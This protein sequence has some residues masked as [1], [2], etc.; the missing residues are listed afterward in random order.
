[1]NHDFLLIVADSIVLPITFT[2]FVLS[3][4]INFHSCFPENAHLLLFTVADIDFT[5]VVPQTIF[6]TIIKIFNITSFLLIFVIIP[7]CLLVNFVKQKSLESSIPQIHHSHKL[8]RNKVKPASN[9][10]QKSCNIYEEVLKQSIKDRPA[11]HQFQHRVGDFVEGETEVEGSS[12]PSEKDERIKITK[13]PT[14]Y[15]NVREEPHI[16]IQENVPECSSIST[17]DKGILTQDEIHIMIE[18]ENNLS[19]E[20]YIDVRDQINESIDRTSEISQVNYKLDKFQKNTKDSVMSIAH[21]SM[22]AISAFFFLTLYSFC[23]EYKFLILFSLSK[24]M[25]SLPILLLLFN[26]KLRTYAKRRIFVVLYKFFPNLKY[27]SNGSQ[28]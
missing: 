13:P 16:G 27:I 17:N 23:G 9:Q 28:E 24:S 6:H 22:A 20:N 8:K 10:V 15:G 5:F 3:L 18:E 2:M 11:I 21:L 1:M 7:I 19:C 4:V 14:M 26:K 12:S 25:E